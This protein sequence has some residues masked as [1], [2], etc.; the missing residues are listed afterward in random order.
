MTI[1]PPTSAATDAVRPSA[2][3]A[4]TA[5]TA[6]AIAAALERCRTA[7]AREPLDRDALREYVALLAG[8]A[9][10]AMPALDAAAAA[11]IERHFADSDRLFRAAD[12]AGA[13]REIRAALALATGLAPLHQ[14]YAELLE[15]R[16]AEDALWQHRVAAALDPSLDDSQW[17]AAQLCGSLG[18]AAEGERRAWAARRLRD[19]DGRR[20]L[21]GLYV[22]AISES[23]EQIAATREAWHRHL[24]QVDAAGLRI[25]DPL[26]GAF[27]PTFYLA[28]HGESD[29][30]PHRRLAAA[31]LRA[32][33]SLAWTSPMLATPEPSRRRLRIGFFSAFMRGHSIGRTTLGLIEH[34]DREQFESHVLS[35]EPY[36]PD[37]LGDRIRAAA[38]HVH[39]VPGT[40][41]E[42]RRSIAALGLDILFYQDIGMLPFAYFLA[43]A[44]LAPVQCTSFGH[45]DT[46]GVPNVD[47]FV[48]V[49]GYEDAG[50]AAEYSERLHLL[51]GVPQ[52]ACY[53]RPR[54]GA[55]RATR[56]DLGLPDD[57]R[58]YV[59]AQTLFKLHPE[60]DALLGGILR[61][62]PRGRVLLLQGQSEQWAAQLR[63]RFARSIPDVATRIVFLPRLGAAAFLELLALADVA[64]DTIHFNGY[65]TSLEAFAVGT[66][67]V[68]M[69]TR[70]QRGRHTALMY[71][72]MQM[73]DCIATSPDDYVELAVSLATDRDRAAD[74]R[75][76]LAERADVL[77]DRRDVVREFERF[78]RE[79][80]AA[81]G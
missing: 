20:L 34:L 41:P 42:A 10:A 58:L 60:F 43:H 18:L 75:A 37:A 55:A 27:S 66:P 23:R 19:E 79:A 32:H 47:W 16:S 68:T 24:E 14:A 54:R 1:P 61:R 50:S 29:V 57:A 22:P 53:E 64:L 62:D 21:A 73:D 76:R 52:L 71:R 39:V 12:L 4:T 5:D 51:R 65:N 36:V 6:A 7:L 35:P 46:S 81:A 30:E 48:S 17:R 59:C 67:V 77:Y 26:V 11:R 40:L 28:Y 2:A 31:W 78:Y 13:E 49:D 80:A 70:L 15:H 72:S 25:A 8:G 9:A 63:A 56:A 69:P 3:V 44:R 74:V 33:P 38:E 45:P